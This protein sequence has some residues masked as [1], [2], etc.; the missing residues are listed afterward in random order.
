MWPRLES[1][2]FPIGPVS[3]SQSDVWI[4]LSPSPLGFP[5]AATRVTGV[6]LKSWTLPP[7]RGLEFLEGPLYLQVVD[8]QG[9]ELGGYRLERR[10]NGHH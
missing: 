2:A 10:R 6:S 9:E 1:S 4:E 3:L 8:D 5:A 7:L